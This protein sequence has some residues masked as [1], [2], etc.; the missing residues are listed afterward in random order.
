MGIDPPLG[1]E[2]LHGVRGL[3]CLIIRLGANGNIY[4]PNI[5]CR[6]INWKEPLLH[7]YWGISQSRFEK[8]G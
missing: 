4:S 6:T 7:K 5:Y 3:L 2:E 8:P 1:S